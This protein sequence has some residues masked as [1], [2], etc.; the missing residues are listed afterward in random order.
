M[1]DKAN[2]ECPKCKGPQ[3]WDNRA[4]KK[5]SKAPDYKCVDR[6][7]DGVIW[8]PKPGQR[9]PVSEPPANAKQP[10]TA[11][12]HIPAIDGPYAANGADASAESGSVAPRLDKLL[13]IY[14]VC[15][16]K[17]H[18]IANRTYGVDESHEATA[19]MAATMYIQSCQALRP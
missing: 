11:G 15:F 14:E 9:S 19:A 7:C 18:E 12:P 17:A 4:S 10:Y 3:M 8:P 1:S 6:N 13:S 2:I 16:D 5:N